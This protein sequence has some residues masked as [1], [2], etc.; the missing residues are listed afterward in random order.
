MTLYLKNRIYLAVAEWCVGRVAFRSHCF[1][2]QSAE[3]LYDVVQLR[4][5]NRDISRSWLN[6]RLCKWGA[7]RWVRPIRKGD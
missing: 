7:N 1:L 2:D 4:E 6:D 3:L 5:S